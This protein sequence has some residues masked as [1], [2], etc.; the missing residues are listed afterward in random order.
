MPESEEIKQKCE[1]SV[2][3]LGPEQVRE[4]VLKLLKGNLRIF[5]RFNVFLE[6][7]AEQSNIDFDK[8]EDLNRYIQTLSNL[9]EQHQVRLGLANHNLEM[10]DEIS[11][12]GH[13][14]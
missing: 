9:A 12:T 4:S 13:S 6:N 3:E 14:I 7:G 2:K 8:L 10:T 1:A 5:A 11:K